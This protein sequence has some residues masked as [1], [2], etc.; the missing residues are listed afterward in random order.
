MSINAV[1]VALKS[2]RERIDNV[3]SIL[4]DVDLHNSN[5]NA[6]PRRKF[7]MSAEGRRKISV[8]MKKRWAAK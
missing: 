7:K 1:I 3:L 6:A 4:Q 2:E 5:G 8:A